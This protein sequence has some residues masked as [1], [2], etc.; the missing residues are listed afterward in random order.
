METLGK[1]E[2]QVLS[3]EEKDNNIYC[4][5]LGREWVSAFK[6]MGNT[7]SD[8]IFIHLPCYLNSKILYS[9]MVSDLEALGDHMTC[10]IFIVRSV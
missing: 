4:K 10:V 9:Y 2:Y 7:M 6:K 5:S 3:K 8:S 1:L